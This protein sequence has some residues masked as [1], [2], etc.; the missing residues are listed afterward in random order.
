MGLNNA[1]VNSQ[2]FCTLNNLP[3]NLQNNLVAYY[4]FC[5]DADDISNNGNHGTVNGAVLTNDRFGNPNSSYFYDGNSYISVNH[6]SDFN[7]GLGSYTLSCWINCAGSSTWQH[8]ITKLDYQSN[9]TSST[10]Y[11]RYANN[12]YFKQYMVL[13]NITP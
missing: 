13:F 9:L 10:M 3:I 5:G 7:F 2:Q 8:A 11:L 1:N 12:I 6:S 4:P